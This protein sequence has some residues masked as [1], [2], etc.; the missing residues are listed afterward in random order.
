MTALDLSTA[1]VLRVRFEISPFRETLEAALAVVGRSPL[2]E[3]SSWLRDHEAALRRLRER[4]DPEL[5]HE[6]M[7]RDDLMLSVCDLNA[8]SANAIDHELA[9]IRTIPDER[10]E[11]G[12]NAPARLAD[13]LAATWR[14][15]V[16]PSWLSIRHRL[17]RDVRYRSRTFAGGGLA[18]VLDELAPPVRLDGSRLLVGA[19]GAGPLPRP[20]GGVGMTLL[21]SAFV[22]R[23]TA[24]VSAAPGSRLALAYPARGLGASRLEH[25]PRPDR[26]LPHLI[27]TTRAQILGVLSEPM[28][29]TAIAER[30]GRSAGNIGDHLGVL[31]SS[32]LIS[33]SRLGRHVFYARTAL[34]AALLA[35]RV[36]D[37][38]GPKDAGERGERRALAGELD[39]GVRQ[40]PIGRR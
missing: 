11:A 30:L 24:R 22:R 18:A 37:E 28:H 9:R 36:E 16:A 39:L 35:G 40:P 1:D 3:H 33:R 19:V 23:G 12:R 21:P 4:M 27:G 20:R 29:T 2:R 5:L 17:E 26:D 10:L 32:G 6:F 38:L 31:R 8:R 25:Q 34:G 15:L 14:E 13:L 7:E